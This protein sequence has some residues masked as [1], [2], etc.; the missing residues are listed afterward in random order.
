LTTTLASQV[1]RFLQAFRNRLLTAH[2]ES[3]GLRAE[4]DAL[5]RVLP[6]GDV[7]LTPVEPQ[8]LPAC[9]YL[10]SALD[11]AIRGP[12]AA[13]AEPIR[14]LG[15]SLRWTYSYPSNA[16]DRT[17]GSKIAFT[18]IVGSKGLKPS[19]EM[20]IGLTLIAPLVSYPAHAHPAIELYLVLAGDAHWQSGGQA[21]TQRLPGSLILH[22][23]DVPHAMSTAGA[24][25]LAIW[26][27][28]GD[29]LAPSVYLDAT[30]SAI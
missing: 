19:A 10:D 21:P 28:R 30:I 23:S 6:G 26:T 5:V 16:K 1:D 9:D 14:L 8:R 2:D 15:P 27:W 3:P 17:L 13:L 7:N 4:A 25:L 12:E 22:P 24:P 29:L 18:Q 20:H 11:L